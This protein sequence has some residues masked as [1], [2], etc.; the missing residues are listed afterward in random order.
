MKKTQPRTN[1][2]IL[3]QAILPEPLRVILPMSS[4]VSIAPGSTAL[5]V[6]RPQH[7]PIWLD[8]LLIRNADRWH[9]DKAEGARVN[10]LPP[11]PASAFAAKERSMLPECLVASGGEIGLDVTYTGTNPEGEPFEA[12]LFGRDRPWAT[13]MPE[14]TIRTDVKI[15]AKSDRSTQIRKNAF[16]LPLPIGESFWPQRLVLD[17]ATH[18]VVNDIRIDDVSLLMQSGDLPGEAFSGSSTLRPLRFGRLSAGDSFEVLATYVGPDRPDP[19]LAYELAGSATRPE[20]N[21]GVSAFFPLS[22]GVSI[23]PG[24]SAQITSRLCIPG[25]FRREFD[26]RAEQI[27]ISDAD[28]WLINDIKVGN[29]SQFA[30]C[31]DIPGVAFSASSV[32]ALFDL[33]I[34]RP[35]MDVVMTVTRVGG[36]LSGAPFVC[37]ISGNAVRL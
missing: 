34:V 23:L 14:A 8:R 13:Q 11:G 37:S 6:G 30:Q 31:G 33:A 12:C 19:I 22:S 28:N 10:W 15:Q 7:G 35:V 18:W 2:R 9:L 1:S 20:S 21:R 24:T 16:R 29:L 17:D 3:E 4:G 36:D 25:D 27:V 32:D 26:F 5:I